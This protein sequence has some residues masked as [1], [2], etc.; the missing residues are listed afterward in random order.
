MR[1]AFLANFD[2]VDQLPGRAVTRRSASPAPAPRAAC[3]SVATH[4]AGGGAEERSRLR[5]CGA[6]RL[7]AVPRAAFNPE[8]AEERQVERLWIFGAGGI[9]GR[10]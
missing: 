2:S 10:S 3:G 9:S 7:A 1:R 5:T 4:H 6:P 8:V